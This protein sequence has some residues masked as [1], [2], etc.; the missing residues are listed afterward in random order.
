VPR[1]VT[2]VAEL[3][4]NNVGKIENSRVVALYGKPED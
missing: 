2:F 3:P 4:K 1:Y